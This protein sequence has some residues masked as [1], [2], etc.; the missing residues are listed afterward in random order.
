[1][2]T[3][4]KK[5][6]LVLWH[7]ADQS[8][9]LMIFS[10]L[11]SNCNSM[12]FLHWCLLDINSWMLVPMYYYLWH[13]YSQVLISVTHFQD[14]GTYLQTKGHEY[15]VTTGRPRRC[16]W[17]DVVMLQYSH[18]INGFTGSVSWKLC[19]APHISWPRIINYLLGVWILTKF[20]S[21]N[22]VISFEKQNFRS[23]EGE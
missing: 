10:S 2:R 3:I 15:G 23:W 6:P 1:M 16:G 7:Y 12:N 21:M 18:M 20:S 14:L 13:A 4:G 19:K 5:F 8:V 17:L 22:F 11:I 9:W